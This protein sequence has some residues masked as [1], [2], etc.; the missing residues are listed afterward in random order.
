MVNTA[1]TYCICQRANLFCTISVYMHTKHCNLSLAFTLSETSWQHNSQQLM[2]F[3]WFYIKIINGAIVKGK[4]FRVEFQTGWLLYVCFIERCC[5]WPGAI[6]VQHCSGIPVCHTCTA[7]PWHTG[8]PHRYSTAVA[9]QCAIPVQH[10]SGIPVSYQY[11]TAVAYQ[12]SIAVAYW[13]A[14]PYSTA[15]VYRCAIP[16]QRC[17]GIP[18][19]HT[20]T[21]L[22]WHT[23]VI[24]V[25]HC[26]GI[27]V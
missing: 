10:C 2:L 1:H 24:P 7:L 5:S 11:S 25:Q 4:S 16:V 17:S 3:C 12:Y 19:C 20:S 26:S 18:V 23:S 21:A 15:V 6:P 9:Y 22:Q 14:I 8:V 27:P 13:C